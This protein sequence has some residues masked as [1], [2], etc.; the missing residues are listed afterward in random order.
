MTVLDASAVLALTLAEAGQDRV[1]AAI[2]GGAEMTT[3][4]FAEV[5]GRYVR[6][7]A[8]A[9]EVQAL[10]DGLPVVLVPVDED[11]AVRAALMVGATRAAGLSLGDRLCL[12][13]AQR[14][15]KPALTAD[16]GWA[17]VA[18]AVGVTV[19]VLR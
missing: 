11:L 16:R 8:S 13:L 14:T 12:A 10:R 19:E 9:A 5:A 17:A 18:A 6:N 2:L 3:V 15:G 1:M 7:G 4:N